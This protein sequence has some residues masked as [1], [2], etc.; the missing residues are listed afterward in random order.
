VIEAPRTAIPKPGAV[1]SLE[2]NHLPE[3]VKTAARRANDAA[4]TVHRCRSPYTREA[5]ET[6][7]SELAAA[8]KTLAAYNPGLPVTHRSPR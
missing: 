3:P 8:N 6:A 7:L 4:V 5:R 1:V 2:G